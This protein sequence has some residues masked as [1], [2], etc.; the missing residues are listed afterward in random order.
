MRFIAVFSRL[1]TTCGLGFATS[2][3]A[4]DFLFW[5]YED[6]E[7]TPHGI[8]DRAMSQTTLYNHFGPLTNQPDSEEVSRFALDY[9]ERIQPQIG[10]PEYN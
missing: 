4:N 2:I 8:F 1:N 3:E 7:L 9:V 10:V 6:N 5:G